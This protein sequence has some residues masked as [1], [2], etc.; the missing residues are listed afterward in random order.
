M[1]ERQLH[2]SEWPI[3]PKPDVLIFIIFYWGNLETF[4][5]NSL[6]LNFRAND[7]FL[8]IKFDQSGKMS[9][10]FIEKLACSSLLSKFQKLKSC[11]RNMSLSMHIKAYSHEHASFTI[12]YEF[13]YDYEYFWIIVYIFEC[14]RMTKLS[15]NV[16][17]FF[18]KSS[19][20]CFRFT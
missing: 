14:N 8:A 16:F 11:V 15:A 6:F 7:H 19:A 1:Q 9:L 20:F 2:S 5:K 12:L 18:D 17:G 4:T 3:P 13:S 10:I